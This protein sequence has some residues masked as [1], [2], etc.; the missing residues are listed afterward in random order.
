[1]SVAPDPEGRGKRVATP[2]A[3]E[4]RP[5]GPPS[6]NQTPPSR[7]STQ[8]PGVA[9]GNK[10]ADR[11]NVSIPD[12]VNR[13]T[14][15]S[16]EYHIQKFPSGPTVM[17]MGLQQAVNSVIWTLLCASR[18]PAV[19]K[20]TRIAAGRISRAMPSPR[21]PNGLTLSGERSG[22]R[23]PCP[24]S[25]STLFRPGCQQPGRNQGLPEVGACDSE[26]LPPPVL[27]RPRFARDC[28]AK[29]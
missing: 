11:K 4:T 18:F 13:L 15:L 2:V 27:A 20:C 9:P 7:P 10:I 22:A 16:P 28:P 23:L 19:R 21:S 12:G 8:C 14:L 25:S 17:A 26:I 3:V 29:S 6:E 1:M 5:I 24:I